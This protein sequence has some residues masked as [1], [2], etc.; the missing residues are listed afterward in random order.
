[1]INTFTIGKSYSFNVDDNVYNK[2]A[3]LM[4][5]GIQTDLFGEEKLWF[6]SKGHNYYFT[7]D[8]ELELAY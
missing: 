5:Q 3:P 2:T 4:F 7:K 1:M 8:I 6:T